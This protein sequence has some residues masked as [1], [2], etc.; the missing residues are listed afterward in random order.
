MAKNV[1][2]GDSPFSDLA[3]DKYFFPGEG[4]IIC[5]GL[6]FDF[7]SQLVGLSGGI[8]FFGAA[9]KKT[10]TFEGFNKICQ[11]LGEMCCGLCQPDD[12]SYGSHIWFK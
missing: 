12:F 7:C 5:E 4:S 6:S 9:P 8:G 2:L 3:T 1:F 10:C 11:N